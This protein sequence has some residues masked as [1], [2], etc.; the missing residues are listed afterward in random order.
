MDDEPYRVTPDIKQAFEKFEE[1]MRVFL[2][3]VDGDDGIT[4]DWMLI[5]AQS[6]ISEG[7]L[8]QTII[9]YSTN[10]NQ[11]GYRTKGLLN[12]IIDRLKASDTAHHVLDHLEG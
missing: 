8:D 11:P 2:A 7:D 9:G 12:T 1:A 4:V 5:T 3:K 10:Y 6:V